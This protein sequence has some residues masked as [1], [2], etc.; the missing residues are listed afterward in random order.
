M[1]SRCPACDTFGLQTTVDHKPYARH[2][3]YKGY[4]ENDES[5]FQGIRALSTEEIDAALN[6][7]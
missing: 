7:D 3:K 4:R 1:A 6:K 2:W 5:S